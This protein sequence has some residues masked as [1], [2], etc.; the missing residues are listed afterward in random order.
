MGRKLWAIFVISQIIGVSLASYSSRFEVGVG[1]AREFL[2][3][4]AMLLLLPGIL[5][6]YAVNALDSGIRLSHWHGLAF[7]AVVTFLNAAFWNFIVLLVRRLNFKA[8]SKA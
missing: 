7:F 6:G 2:W 1:G 5:F 4:P 3:M 8:R